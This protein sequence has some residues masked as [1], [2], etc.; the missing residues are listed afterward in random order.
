MINQ[1]LYKGS[2]RLFK[3]VDCGVVT[4]VPTTVP[5][6][7]T[8]YKYDINT[9]SGDVTISSISSLTI[10]ATT[11][12][13][14]KGDE[15]VFTNLGPNSVLY[16]NGVTSLSLNTGDVITLIYTGTVLPDMDIPYIIKTA[17]QSGKSRKRISIQATVNNQTSFDA[18]INIP[19]SDEVE[20][21]TGQGHRIFMGSG[22]SISGSIVT[23]THTEYQVD[24]GEVVQVI[25]SK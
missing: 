1:G 5:E 16:T 6:K 4:S 19:L 2:Q 12:V 7:G 24:L 17:L 25:Y 11:S 22:F 23:I 14:E 21:Y 18:G 13:I 8:I 20:L 3:I 9:N 10:G 15:I